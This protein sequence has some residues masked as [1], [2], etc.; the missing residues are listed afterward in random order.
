MY[1]MYA[2]WSFVK[3]LTAFL[4]W[5]SRSMYMWETDAVIVLFNPKQCISCEMQIK[6]KRVQQS[7][8]VL[9]RLV[10]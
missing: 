1:G 6:Y 5:R 10:L 3:T 4:S 9:T 2:A 7:Y 8:R